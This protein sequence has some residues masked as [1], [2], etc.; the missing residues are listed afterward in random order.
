[1]WYCVSSK[2]GQFT[3]P[4]SGRKKTPTFYRPTDPPLKFRVGIG[5]TNIFLIVALTSEKDQEEQWTEHFRKILNRPPPA[6][7][8]EISDPEYD[9]DI[10]TEPP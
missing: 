9:L 4:F 8:H 3:Q 2:Y 10:S 1:M 5:E 6:Q 7:E